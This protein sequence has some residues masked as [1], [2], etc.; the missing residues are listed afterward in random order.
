MTASRIEEAYPVS[1]D[2]PLGPRAPRCSRGIADVPGVLLGELRLV[3]RPES[4]G[5]A[6]RF[7]R[8]IAVSWEISEVLETAELL[9]S[10]LVG[11]AARHARGMV[12]STLRV[13]VTRDRDRLRVEVPDPD[14]QPPQLR[15]ADTIDE[16]GRGLVLVSTLAADFGTYP[17]PVGKSVW[18]DLPAWSPSGL[19]GES[20]GR[21]RG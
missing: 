13:L 21:G 3:N 19:D 17:T 5:I 12:G 7:V 10:E 18:F 2:R 14:R 4:A 1:V 6:R 9:V 15:R 11:N 8:L 20:R 16:A